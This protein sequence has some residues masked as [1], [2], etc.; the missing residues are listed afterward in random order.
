M[1]KAAIQGVF[2]CVFYMVLHWDMKERWLL[3]LWVFLIFANVF[4]GIKAFR[5]RRRDERLEPKRDERR[6]R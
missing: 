5:D 1:E 2:V 4:F 6:P 3:W